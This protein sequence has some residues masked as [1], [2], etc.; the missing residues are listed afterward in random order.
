[1]TTREFG[2]GFGSL[3]TV[4]GSGKVWSWSV[5]RAGAV[6]DSGTRA[7]GSSAKRRALE[8]AFESLVIA[9]TRDGRIDKR[10]Q[11]GPNNL[12]VA[13]T[14]VYGEDSYLRGWAR[15]VTADELLGAIRA[16]NPQSILARAAR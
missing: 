11:S 2:L 14:M 15:S 7:S 9:E 10:L 16:R 3:V 5:S 4:Q 8:V 1:M 13:H 12:L 6:T